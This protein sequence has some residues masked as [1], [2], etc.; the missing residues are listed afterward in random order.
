MLVQHT[1]SVHWE[2]FPGYDSL[3]REDFP[4]HKIPNPSETSLERHMA[5]T[6][7][8]PGECKAEC[9][10]DHLCHGF[11]TFHG[12]CYFR[13][14][15]K[16]S[17]GHIRIARERHP[18]STLYI[19]FGKHNEPPIPPPSPP[20]PPPSSP[21]PS[22]LPPPSPAPASPP[23]SPS[24]SQPAPP[25]TPLVGAIHQISDGFVHMIDQNLFA[26]LCIAFLLGG[27][28]IITL[29]LNWRARSLVDG[30]L[31]RHVRALRR[32]NGPST[33]AMERPSLPPPSKVLREDPS[34]PRY[35]AV[36]LSSWHEHHASCAHCTSPCPLFSGAHRIAAHPCW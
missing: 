3:P 14:G 1:N 18:D 15:R 13:G 36:R 4:V 20:P 10:A 24:P 17:A 30:S 27:S 7:E 26:F 12:Q 31:L 28:A 23:P 6:S 16:Y 22:P 34:S 19:L 29:L 2:V 25:A 33:A 5:Y 32:G 11:V 9:L 35:T 21:P 8:P